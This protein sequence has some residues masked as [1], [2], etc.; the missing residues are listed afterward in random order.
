MGWEA[1]R[2]LTT[3]P[4]A[5]MGTASLVLTTLEDSAEGSR[6]AE[7]WDALRGTRDAFRSLSAGE[8]LK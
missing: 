5:E 3:R 1:A 2:R 6:S 8:I 7:F 4:P